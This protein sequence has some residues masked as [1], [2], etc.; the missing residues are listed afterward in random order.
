MEL[1]T[2]RCRVSGFVVNIFEGYTCHSCRPRFVRYLP[3]PG[4][5]CFARDL[6][7]GVGTLQDSEP[8]IITPSDI[9]GTALLGCFS[10]SLRGAAEGLEKQN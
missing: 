9:S 6:T 2:T 5:F 3:V 1:W 10:N 4:A 8:D 7:S